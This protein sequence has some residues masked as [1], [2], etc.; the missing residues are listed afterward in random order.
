MRYMKSYNDWD[1]VPNEVV[2]MIEELVL[3]NYADKPDKKVVEET[4]AAV[5]MMDL[6]ML[7]EYMG[8]E[9]R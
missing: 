7:K 1:A 2:S 8:F 3:I 6:D 5:E 4:R 9:P